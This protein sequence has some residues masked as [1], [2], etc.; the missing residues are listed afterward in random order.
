MSAA[1]RFALAAGAVSV[2]VP[3]A[4]RGLTLRETAAGAAT[5]RVHDGTSASGALLASVGVPAGGSLTVMDG[6]GVVFTAGL[7]VE[8]SGSVQGSL[9]VG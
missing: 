7:F 8:I 1:R 6:A 4:L 5:V 2:G 9:F 3:G